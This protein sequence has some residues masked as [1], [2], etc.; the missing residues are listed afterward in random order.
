MREDPKTAGLSRAATPMIEV[1]NH[2]YS[3]A[4]STTPACTNASTALV[5][6]DPG[7]C[8]DRGGIGPHGPG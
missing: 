7:R 8:G 6:T 2:R 4:M 3:E 5:I 1:K